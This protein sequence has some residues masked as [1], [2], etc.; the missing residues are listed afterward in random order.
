[1]ILNRSEVHRRWNELLC[2]MIARKNK[3]I[4]QYDFDVGFG[5]LINEEIKYF[6]F[7]Q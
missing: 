5:S 6:Q 4:F 2:L 1:M 3:R 7:H